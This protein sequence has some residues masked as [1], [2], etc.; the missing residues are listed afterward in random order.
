MSSS[1]MGTT[2]S[3]R[4]IT[5]GGR[6]DAHSFHQ[7]SIDDDECFAGDIDRL[8]SFGDFRR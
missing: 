4:M 3:V 8:G 5:I 7:G 1:M 6:A 2:L